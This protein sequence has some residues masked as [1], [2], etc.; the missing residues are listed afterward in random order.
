MKSL[1][2]TETL[3]FVLLCVS[4]FPWISFIVFIVLK[5]SCQFLTVDVSENARRVAKSVDPVCFV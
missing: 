1:D 3:I 2:K 4:L 5:F